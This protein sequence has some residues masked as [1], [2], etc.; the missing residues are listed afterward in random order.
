[1][2]VQGDS[3]HDSQP[4]KEGDPQRDCRGD[5]PS[6]SDRRLQR[7]SGGDFQGDLQTLSRRRD[8]HHGLCQV[9]GWSNAQYFRILRADAGAECVR[10]SRLP[11]DGSKTPRARVRFTAE[12]G[13][14]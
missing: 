7:D 13:W 4:E 3:G 10:V 14:P 8:S 5:A 1:M 11:C 12:T 2:H 6:D 9:A